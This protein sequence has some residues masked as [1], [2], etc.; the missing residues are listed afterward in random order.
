[1]KYNIF[2]TFLEAKE[3][4]EYDHLFQK[5]FGLATA[6]GIDLALIRELNLHIKNEQ[7]ELPLDQYIA[8]N[9]IVIEH[10]EIYQL[11]K[12]HWEITTAWAAIYKYNESFVYRKDHSDRIYTVIELE[13][14]AVLLPVDENGDVVIIGSDL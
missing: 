6:S 3:S 14:D 2:T 13:S 10:P 5:S 11:S 12:K 1:M 9:A 4:Q 8:D 7:G